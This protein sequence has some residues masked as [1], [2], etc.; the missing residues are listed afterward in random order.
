MKKQNR[1]CILPTA[2]SPRALT[3]VKSV[4]LRATVYH[5]GA[6]VSYFSAAFVSSLVAARVLTTDQ[7][8]ASQYSM[9]LAQTAWLIASIGVP[10]ALTR[11]LALWTAEGHPGA[12]HFLLRATRWIS[13]AGL[14]LA[15][16]AVAWM[17]RN[18]APA[19]TIAS[20]LLCAAVG[21][22]SYWLAVMAGR[23]R[24]DAIF[25]AT[26]P[27]SLL[28]LVMIY[29]VTTR[30]GLSG[31][32]G[33]QALILGVVGLA[34]M[35][36][37]QEQYGG[38]VAPA[39]PAGAPWYAGVISYASSTWAALLVSA[40]VWQRGELYF[41]EHFLGLGHTGRVQFSAALFLTDIICR[42]LGLTVGALLP[43]FTRQIGSG[44][45]SSVNDVFRVATKL[46]AW[47]AFLPL[48][49]LALNAN[50]IA[51]FVFGHRFAE[52]ANLATTLSI[53]AGIAVVAMP[54][55]SLIYAEGKAAFILKTGLAGAILVVL[56]GLWVV[57]EW[58]TQGAACARVLIQGGLILANVMYLSALGYR[59]PVCAYLWCAALAIGACTVP[60]LLFGPGEMSVGS[61]AWRLL[62]VVFLYTVATAFVSILDARERAWLADAWKAL[63][64]RWNKID[65]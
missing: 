50:E 12:I 53:G 54:G 61:L 45:R 24:Y 31:Y 63:Q 11:F 7:F 28:L 32:L 23:N 65:R 47:A 8:G 29:P 1:V 55:S 44:D 58:G 43:N 20:A 48:A 9:W 46:L 10:Q 34:L 37:G 26:T 38:G 57:P 30:F 40:L 49:F 39:R 17:T 13:A 51:H 25:R 21:Y 27:P 3:L 41:I 56:A 2:T 52:A 59:F 60:I 35:R 4:L 36:T 16:C 18:L 22:H 33:L 15:I 14:A 64:T 62:L 6:T 19:E 5:V 42:P